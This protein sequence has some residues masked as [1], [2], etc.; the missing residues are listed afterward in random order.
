MLT[1]GSS[2]GGLKRQAESAV[3]D[4]HPLIEKV[5]RVGYVGKGIVYGL[6]GVLAL[7][8]AIG[9]GGDTTD[10]QGAINAIATLP[11]GR[12]LLYAIAVG[13]AG[14]A[15]WRVLLA[16]FNPEDKKP[17]KRI[18][19]AATGVIYGFLGWV[20]FEVARGGK[21]S[22]DDTTFAAQLMA[23]PFGR[24]LVLALGAIVIGVAIAQ[25]VNAYKA[26]FKSILML[27]RMS[28]QEQ[29]WAVIA[30]RI[31]LASRGVVFLLIGGFFL[32]A[33]IDHNPRESGGLDDA[34]RKVASVPFGQWALG[35]V[36]LGF[37]CYA[38][39]MFIEARYRRMV[40]PVS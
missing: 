34:L 30:G 22:G 18:G 15:I 23:Q 13:L 17:I 21:A 33:G 12:A 35:A 24:Y 32:K 10:K 19:Y 36:A 20:S 40:A 39:F 27:D 38:V 31:G 29:R 3:S 14:Y 9:P 25:F 11:F 6:I 7:L 26:L 2:V 5:A 28:E 1:P 4:A 16:Y 8:A 37:V